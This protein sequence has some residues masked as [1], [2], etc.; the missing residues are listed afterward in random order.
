MA[1]NNG[2]RLLRNLLMLTIFRMDFKFDSE[3]ATIKPSNAGEQYLQ[4][5]LRLELTL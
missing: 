1:T 3:L 4:A 5:C 2:Y